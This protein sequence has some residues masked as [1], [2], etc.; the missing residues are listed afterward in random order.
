MRA[1]NIIKND[2]KKNYRNAVF[3]ILVLICAPMLIGFIETAIFYKD[4]NGESTLNEFNISF[5]DKDKNTY[6]SMFRK[7][8]N[9]KEIKKELNV[10]IDF[11]E[12]KAQAK[13]KDNEVSA[14]V[15]IPRDFT[16]SL[17]AG[18]PKEI[19][20]LKSYKDKINDNMVEGILKSFVDRISLK[21]RK[22][23]YVDTVIIKKQSRVDAAQHYYTVM[24]SA[25]IILS[26]FIL[27]SDII[28]EKNENILARIISTGTNKYVYFY[29]KLASIFIICTIES[30][31]YVVLTSMIF[32]IDYGN[33]YIDIL[34]IVISGSIAITG[35]TAI[36]IGIIKKLN[37]FRIYSSMLFMFMGIFS[38]CFGLTIETLPKTTTQFAP[39]TFNY[40]Y[41]KAYNILMLGGNMNSI[42]IF[43]LKLSSFGIIASILGSIIF[44]VEVNN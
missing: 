26:V 18:N 5:V 31:I 32:N 40:N 34:S 8:L 30:I 38:G 24:F 20:F 19:K 4:Y 39:Y 43:I 3:L 33:K 1:V 37:V 2:L 10:Q 11:D 21:G 23:N 25:F 36:S 9:G 13:V 14:A 15:I 41:Y 44:K 17:I 6:G 16:E 42:L 12:N 7:M 35:L 27:G 22:V 28:E 29:S